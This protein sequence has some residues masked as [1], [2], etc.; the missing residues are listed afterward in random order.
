METEIWVDV[1]WYEWKYQV[2]NLWRVKSLPYEYELNRMPRWWEKSWKKMIYEKR[3]AKERI[4]PT[5]DLDWYRRVH[6][7]IWKWKSK[8]YLVHRIV[9]LSFNNLPLLWL[10][11]KSKT[12]IL[13]K[14]D[15]RDDNR[16]DNLFIW[17]QDDNIKDMMD[18]WR[19][20][21]WV[22]RKVK[23]WFDDINK[24]KEKYAELK[25]IYK[26][27]PLFWVSYSTISR[28]INWVN[29]NMEKRK[30]K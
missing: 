5:S 9:Y 3:Y 7:S 17:T 23:I 1:S 16:L 30:N 2:S 21:N 29:W 8:C 13:H 10:W 4:L 28:A 15:I 24:I 11:Q 19:H 14:N 22:V 26:V 12:L 20:K 18:K 25:S 27:A 6:L